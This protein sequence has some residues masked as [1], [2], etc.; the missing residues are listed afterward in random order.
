MRVDLLSRISAA[1]LSSV[2]VSPGFAQAPKAA[3]HVDVMATMNSI[4]GARCATDMQKAQRGGG[5]KDIDERVAAAR[6]ALDCVRSNVAMAVADAPSDRQFAMHQAGAEAITYTESLYKEAKD[7]QS[8]LGLTW[9]LGFGFS[10]SRREAITDATIVNGVVRVSAQ[11]KQQA[12]VLMEFHQ[13]LWGHEKDGGNRGFGPFVAI[14]AADDKVLSGVGFGLMYGQKLA[15]QKDG[16]SV[17]A[18]LILDNKVK[19]L[20]SGFK[21]DEPAPNG[22]TAVRFEEKSRWSAMVFVTRTF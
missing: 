16:F 22:E 19:D 1:L 5:S 3:A 13:F 4:K 14:A 9:G 21:K 7:E 8:F 11:Q 18:G 15:D 12:R 2:I 20:G 17:G 6:R 10:F